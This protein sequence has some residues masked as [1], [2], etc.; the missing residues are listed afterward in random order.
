MIVSPAREAPHAVRLGH[1]AGEHDHREIR[2]DPRRQAV[3]CAQPVEQVESAAVLE[4]EIEH[5]EVRLTYLDRS[6]ALPRTARPRD[7]KAV[8]RQIVEQELASGLVV[9]HNQ[10]QALVIHIPRKDRERESRPGWRRDEEAHSPAAT[11]RIAT[12]LISAPRPARRQL[13]LD[14]PNTTAVFQ[15]QERRGAP[16]RLPQAGGLTAGAVA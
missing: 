1:P 11:C 8:G 9:L 13:T 10:D 3:G 2:V 12:P 5:H 16:L 6:Q 7:P 15:K 4:G 14:T